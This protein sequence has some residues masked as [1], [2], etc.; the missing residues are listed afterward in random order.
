MKKTTRSAFTIVELMIVIAILMD[1]AVIAL[2]AFIRS[3]DMAQNT[4]F[5]VD[6]RTAAGAFEMYSAENNNYPPSANP[7]VIPNGMAVYLA[8]FP[9]SSTNSIGSQWL[10]SPNFQNCTATIQVQ[11]ASDPGDVRMVDI[12]TRMDNGILATGAFRQADSL[13]YFYIIEP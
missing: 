13:N 7:G 12:D 2:P 11:F 10:W 6:L 4:K 8:N 3:R 9:W 1:L 5:I